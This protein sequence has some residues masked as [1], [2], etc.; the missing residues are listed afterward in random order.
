MQKALIIFAVVLLCACRKD[1]EW[2]GAATFATFA[3]NIDR[4][5]QSAIVTADGNVVVVGNNNTYTFI[6]KLTKQGQPVWFKMYGNHA[7]G[8]TWLGNIL[9]EDNSGN[10]Y[11][12]GNGSNG[13]W[14]AVLA[15]FTNMGDT[16]WVKRYTINVN[17]QS[18]LSKGLITTADGNIVM[19]GNHPNN[20]FYAVKISPAGQLL[21]TRHCQHPNSQQVE[22]I[23]ESD[24]DF[25]IFGK[26]NHTGDIIC[27]KLNGMGGVV[28]E[29][30][31]EINGVN[32]TNHTIQLAN[33]HF[34]FCGIA[35]KGDDRQAY[36]QLVDEDFTPLWFK[37]YGNAHIDDF[38]LTATE[39]TPG[40][41]AMGG[42]N[43]QDGHHD[44]FVLIANA[45]TGDSICYSHFRS[46]ENVLYSIVF[47]EG[48]GRL[49]LVGDR[50]LPNSAMGIYITH[51]NSQGNFN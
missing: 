20:N 46:E 9:V 12:G 21:W 30:A 23:I 45:A 36:F 2:K 31:L 26:D 27:K 18:W 38:G 19:A 25:Y 29:R 37:R 41:I 1:T 7:D 51:T 24:G 50:D 14:G 35:S 4:N 8:G 44:G 28:W 32:T 49:M 16:M 3:A 22:T 13:Q 5:P 40:K 11:V 48:N 34:L 42:Y 33:G 15:K 17:N 6:T 47:N 39:Y 43:F 10:L